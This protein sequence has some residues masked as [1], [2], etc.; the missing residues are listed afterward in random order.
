[1]S[2]KIVIQ[3]GQQGEQPQLTGTVRAGQKV[4]IQKGQQ[5]DVDIT[6]V[7][8]TTQSMDDKIEALLQTTSNF[9][10][11][12][13]QLELNAQ[14]CIIAFGDIKVVGGGDTIQVVTPL[15]SDIEAVRRSL[16]KM[17]RNRGF[18]NDGESSM[19]ALELAL[20][21]PYRSSAVKVIVLV[22][23]DYAHQDRITAAQMTAQLKQSEFLVFVLAV[24]T[25]YY[26]D[27]A[28]QNG[29]TWTEISED[30]S[31]SDLLDMFRDMASIISKTT[32]EVHVLGTGSVKKY[33]ALNPPKQS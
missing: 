2:K 5:Q 19:E 3:S 32:K 11:D 21:Q 8:D 12:F 4:V 9:V 22:T 28:T 14:F 10:S 13:S 15:T 29:G 17:P 7:V 33:L 20:K 16:R 26:R 23:D 30:S 6:F 27:M 25:R 24:N 31:L 1:M 18:G